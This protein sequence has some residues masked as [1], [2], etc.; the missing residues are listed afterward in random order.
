MVFRT[1]MI[2]LRGIPIGLHNFSA[3]EAEVYEDENMG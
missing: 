3:G 2:N 1:S